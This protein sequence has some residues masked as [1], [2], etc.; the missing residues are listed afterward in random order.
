[1]A[2]KRLRYPAKVMRK[3]LRILDA[4]ERDRAEHGHGWRARWK[5]KLNDQPDEQLHFEPVRQLLGARRILGDAFA[6]ILNRVGPHKAVLLASA[7]ETG[8]LGDVLKPG[9]KLETDDGRTWTLEDVPERWL[10]RLLRRG[11]RH[12][13][14]RPPG[15][16]RRWMEV[17]ARLHG[18]L[19][20][21]G[22]HLTT[23]FERWRDKKEPSRVRKLERRAV[24][25]RLRELDDLHGVLQQLVRLV[26][27]TRKLHK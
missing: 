17:L 9:K 15:G 10:R 14:G 6:G 7:K 8:R 18:S 19:A 20:P 3:L 13:P 4:M 1:M 5:D 27:S 24:A 21:M 2:K 12:G 11:R 16:S 23:A 25:L 26:R 22:P